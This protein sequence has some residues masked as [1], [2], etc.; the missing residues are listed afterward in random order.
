VLQFKALAMPMVIVGL[1]GLIAFVEGQLVTPWLTSR[2]AEMNAVAVF[3]G[4][5]FWG[6]AWGP[7]GLLLAVPLMMMFKAVGEHVESL[8]PI[9]TLLKATAGPR[10]NGGATP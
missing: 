4:L 9:V 6:W 3:V 5:A 8:R 7:A 2:A 10:A 1:T